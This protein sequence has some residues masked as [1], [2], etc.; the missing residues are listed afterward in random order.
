MNKNEEFKI[1]K[2]YLDTFINI[3]IDLYDKG[4]DY[5][6]IIG[7]TDD[8]Q[9]VVKI[10]FSKE[11]MNKEMLENFEKLPSSVKKEDK[12][13]LNLSDDDINQLL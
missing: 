8:T 11:Y 12:I 2:V 7:S 3:L 1:R 4:V 13:N 6:D 5:I 10:S 9:D